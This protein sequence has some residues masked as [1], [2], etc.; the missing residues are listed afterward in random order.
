MQEVYAEIRGTLARTADKKNTTLYKLHRQKVRQ[1]R[2]EKFGFAERPK[3]PSD[4]SSVQGAKHFLNDISDEIGHKIARLSNSNLHSLERDG[5]AVI[6]ALNSEIHTL[7]RQ[8]EKWILRVAQL[9]QQG[10]RHPAGD[11][12][13]KTGTAWVPLTFFGCA[14]QLP[15][16]LEAAAKAASREDRRRRAAEART[17]RRNKKQRTEEN[18][19]IVTEDDDFEGDEQNDA[20]NSFG[21]GAALSSAALMAPAVQ[22]YLA[23][24]RIMAE[25]SKV[26]ASAVDS[27][28]SMTVVSGSVTS[29]S[30]DS[31]VFGPFGYVMDFVCA[32]AG[33]PSLPSFGQL[34]PVRNPEVMKQFLFQRKKEALRLQAAKVAAK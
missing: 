6:R 5:E 3:Y 24:I 18:S 25:E 11:G 8:K 10:P 7:L 27:A 23:R 32:G 21:V 1:D 15:E 2:A 30:M 19:E 33:E 28:N 14:K 29:S 31:S 4:C 9:E 20:R 13:G 17:A 12:G 22:D 26:A 34:L 16:A